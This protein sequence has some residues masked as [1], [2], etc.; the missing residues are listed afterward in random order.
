MAGRIMSKSPSPPVAIFNSVDALETAVRPAIAVRF[1]ED[2]ERAAGF[3]LEYKQPSATFNAYRREIERLCLWAWRIEARSILELTREDITRLVEFLRSPPRSW[4]GTKTVAR[5]R[6]DGEPNPDWRP[7]VVSVKKARAREGAIASVDRYEAS[8]AQLKATMAILSSFYSM[9]VNDGIIPANP[10]IQIRQKSRFIVKS[11]EPAPV[12]RLSRLQ[13]EY[14]LDTAEDLSARE[15]E[16]YER[17]LFILHCLYSMYL[18]VSELVPGEHGTPVMGNFRKDMDQNWWFHVIG[19]GKKARRIVVSDDMLDALRR[20]RT[21]LGRSPLPMADD[22]DP[23]LPKA[24]GRGAIASTRQVRA[25]VQE[26]FDRAFERMRADGLEDDALE[27]KASSAHWLR[28]TGISEDVRIRPR[29][30]VRDDAGHASMAT[31]DRY[32]DSDMRERHASGKKKMV[33]E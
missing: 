4:I 10:V 9:M 7:F 5:V 31:T 23:L 13:W 24:K 20:Y 28:H 30:H 14:V 8:Q 18:R 32:V 29:E 33:R 3:L 15:A 12:R 26:M 27:L 1:G 11:T 16:R 19:K 25:L 21:H 2:Y 6:R 17:S 22:T